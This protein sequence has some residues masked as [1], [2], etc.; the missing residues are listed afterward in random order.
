MR[1]TKERNPSI[2]RALTP[3]EYRHDHLSHVNPSPILPQFCYC[4]KLSTLF[5][6]SKFSSP[7]SVC[8]L[9]LPR[10][11]SFFCF[12]SHIKSYMYV[13]SATSSSDLFHSLLPLDHVLVFFSKLATVIFEVN[14]VLFET[15]FS[16]LGIKFSSKTF[17]IIPTS[18][19]RLSSSCRQSFLLIEM[20]SAFLITVTYT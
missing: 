2:H 11:F 13:T 14:F 6:S 3:D 19:V 7:I 1:A 9:F 18:V 20:L 15:Y 16:L 10:L 5:K 8:L 12:T 4:Q 17:L